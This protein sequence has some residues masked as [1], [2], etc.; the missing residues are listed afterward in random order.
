M[1]KLDLK[2]PFLDQKRRSWIQERRF[3]AKNGKVGLE[4]VIFA[5]KTP[6]LTGKMAIPDRIISF[7]RL[8]S[9]SLGWELQFLASV[10]DNVRI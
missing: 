4:I 7:N 2:S 9:G 5:P 8:K 6:F 10:S 1:G 3:C